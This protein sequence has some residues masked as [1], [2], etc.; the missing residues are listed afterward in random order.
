MRE[1]LTSGWWL[2]LLVAVI[3][4]FFHES[5]FFGSSLVPSD[6]LHQLFLPY[7]ASVTHIDV[8]YHYAVDVVTD[9][10]PDAVF[11]QQSVRSGELPLWNPY[12]FGGHPYLGASM[13]TALSPFKLLYLVLPAER[14]FSLGIVLEFVLAGL[15]M[16]LFLRSLD[17]SHCAAFI[18]S[19][20]YSLNSAFVL[21]Y[22]FAPPS[23]VWVPLT[24]LLF[25]RSV[26]RDSWY[27][28]IGSGLVLGLAYLSGNVQ[29]AFYAGFV[30]VSYFA[31]S[32]FG[33]EPAQRKRAIIRASLVGLIGA[34]VALPQW[35][36][37]WELI[38]RQGGGQEGITHRQHLQPSL[39]HTV[40]GPLFLLE[41]V[42]P[43]LAGSPE[44]YDLT[45]LVGSGMSEF[46]GYIGVVPFV[47][48]LCGASGSRDW[49]VRALLLVS[50]GVFVL[51]F[52]T[53][54][55]RY[56]YHRFF[57]VY[58]FASATIAGYGTDLLLNPSTTVQRNVRRAFAW[59]AAVC[60]A[61]VIG[62]LL[63]QLLVHARRDVLLT[64]ANQYVLAHLESS[65]LRGNQN[66]AL[67]R[68][69]LFVDRFRI[70]S[71]CFWIPIMSFAAAG[72]CWLAYARMKIGRAFLAAVLVAATA[73]DL[74]AMGRSWLPQIDLQKYPLYPPVKVLAPVLADHDL[75]RVDHWVKSRR[76]ILP[77]SSLMMY[78]IACLQGNESI[79]PESIDSLPHEV[80]GKFNRLLDLQN[81]KYLVTDGSTDLPAERFQLVAEA[82]GTRIYRNKDCLPR[83]M[84]VPRWQ[85]E[86]DRT[87]ILAMMTAESFDPREIVFL[88]HEPSEKFAAM[89][90]AML[91]APTNGAA[92]VQVKRYAP[93]RMEVQVHSPTDGVV[94]VADTYYPGWK[95]RVDGQEAHVYR[96]D[97]ILRG[98]FV[99][100]GRHDIQFYY[101]A[102]QSFRFGAA[103]AI[104]AFAVW[105]AFGV[106]RLGRCILVGRRK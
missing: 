22:W 17:R 106:Q 66:W 4:W 20:A 68:V 55:S 37:T 84:F 57:V 59:M 1:R 36:P 10:Y 77:D 52:F 79:W 29:S 99:P 73:T 74:V 94:L 76:L 19:L 97:Y 33:V 40:F 21:G 54:M 56:V 6:I 101:D 12:L 25:E 5:I 35:L 85:V 98:V 42:F 100:A 62:L 32:V 96:A 75:F 60:A 48:F 45:K 64:K 51:V 16:F 3:V 49:R 31:A 50:A 103:M 70:T 27:A 69:P 41:F 87:K 11:W 38:M 92:H 91:M 14:A 8:Q 82:A 26:Q 58:V 61:V 80:N 18:G 72:A 7:S 86:R 15:F 102:P 83:A 88:E 67:A 39:R 95:A 30:C 28:A 93:R 13:Q 71:A 24:L 9:H 89:Q 46:T 47:L 53:P 23:F 81:V 104:T 63:V 90:P 44:T 105:L 43:A 34:M 65:A 2:A 78:G